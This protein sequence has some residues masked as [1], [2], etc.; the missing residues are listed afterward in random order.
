MSQALILYNEGGQ[1]CCLKD[2]LRTKNLWSFQPFNQKYYD[3]P[4]SELG[5]EKQRLG[6][7]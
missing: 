7:G 1:S 4:D 5:K 2:Y 6:W 3:I